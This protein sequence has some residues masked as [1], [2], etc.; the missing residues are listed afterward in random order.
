V[1]EVPLLFPYLTPGHQGLKD[2]LALHLR[3]HYLECPDQEIQVGWS[4]LPSEHP[5]RAGAIQKCQASSKIPLWNPSYRPPNFTEHLRARVLRP[6]NRGR[7]LAGGGE[8]SLKIVLEVF[9]EEVKFS[10][11][12]ISPVDSYER[13]GLR[14]RPLFKP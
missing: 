10:E 8:Q 7:Y 13:G 6:A 5:R 4:S 11:G 2:Q 1:P 14:G 9:K 3:L 12:R